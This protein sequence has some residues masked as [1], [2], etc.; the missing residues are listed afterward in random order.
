[1]VV[2]LADLAT[3]LLA[4]QDQLDPKDLLAQQEP[5]VLLEQLAQRAIRA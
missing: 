3:A 1:M 4:L 2:A 5:L